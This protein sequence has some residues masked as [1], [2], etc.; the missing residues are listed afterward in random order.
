MNC[1]KCGSQ[2]DHPGQGHTCLGGAA[3]TPQPPAAWQASIWVLVALAV[4]FAG[5]SLVRAAISADVLTPPAGKVIT[6]LSLA[7]P[8]A[9]LIAFLAWSNRTKGVIDAR[10][11]PVTAVRHWA[12]PLGTLL[13]FLS[14]LL[15]MKT[16]TAFH[17]VRAAAA[18]VLVIGALITHGRAG[19]AAPP[20]TATE[21]GRQGELPQQSPSGAPPAWAPL[22]DVDTQPQDWNASLWDPEVQQDIER[23]RRRST[24]PA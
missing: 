13:I 21:P 20:D 1:P 15:P 18:I 2:L 17:A 11:V 19:R 23:R 14:Y 5:L 4:L 9:L 6:A 22:L 7:A 8:L 12:V 16:P 24:P 3:P 10:G